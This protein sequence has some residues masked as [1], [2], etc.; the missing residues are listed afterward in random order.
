MRKV[1]LTYGI[2]AGFI[3]AVLMVAS[4]MLAS[5]GNDEFSNSEMVGYASMIISL[6]MIYFGIRKY[7]DNYSGGAITFGKAFVLGLYITL[8][9]SILYVICWKIYSAIALPD[10]ADKY[11]GRMIENLKKSGA[12]DSV[13]ALKTKDMAQW[14]ELYKNPIF[15]LGMTFMEIFPVGL[16]IS[17]VCAF[18]LKRKPKVQAEA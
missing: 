9:A 1:A 7:R 10:F 13:V 11:A 12:S 6:S 3:G 14:K 4:G 5:S 2:L 8:I 16:L 18:I 15:E 17:L